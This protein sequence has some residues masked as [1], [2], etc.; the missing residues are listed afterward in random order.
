MGKTIPKNGKT[1]PA[2]RI[3]VRKSRIHGRGVFAREQIRKG[4]R[5]I[6]YTGRRI[7]WKDAQELP[8]LDSTN[9]YHTVFFSVDNGD[10]I[11]A[12]VGGNE[13][14]WINHSCEPNC[15]TFEEDYRIFVHALRGLRPGEE[16]FYDYKMIPAERRSRKVEKEFACFCGAPKCRGTMLAPRKKRKK[17]ANRK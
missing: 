12:A 9:P 13:A 10:V 1:K 6:E 11:D 16:L 3:E 4:A 2:K 17:P 14:R 8:P 7:P 15:E 5:I